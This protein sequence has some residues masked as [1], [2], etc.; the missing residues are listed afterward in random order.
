MVC[1]SGQVKKL[2]PAGPLL[3]PAPEK[4]YGAESRYDAAPAQ[5]LSKIPGY[6]GQDYPLYAAVST[7]GV[8]G[9]VWGTESDYPGQDYPLYAAVSTAEVGGWVW[10]TESD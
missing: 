5:D 10:G 4:T 6:P 1:V 2:Q 9:W 3:Y 7:A 8:G